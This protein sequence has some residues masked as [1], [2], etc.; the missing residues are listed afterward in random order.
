MSWFTFSADQTYVLIGLVVAAAFVAWAIYFAVQQFSPSKD[1][2]TAASGL[3]SASARHVQFANVAD[4]SYASAY[5]DMHP[6]AASEP[7]VPQASTAHVRSHTGGRAR[8][9]MIDMDAQT[10]SGIRATEF[11]SGVGNATR[12]LVSDAS[13]VISGGLSAER[14]IKNRN[15]WA[16]FNGQTKIG[17]DGGAG[18]WR[19]EKLVPIHPSLLNNKNPLVHLPSDF[20]KHV[21]ANTQ[22][23]RVVAKDHVTIGGQKDRR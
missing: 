10:T 1:T 3:K 8:N 15:A 18:I 7:L 17:G 20:Y 14:K 5:G 23:R 12:D 2:K 21:Y 11:A 19:E 22:D 13:K 9:S 4:N 16:I 6:A